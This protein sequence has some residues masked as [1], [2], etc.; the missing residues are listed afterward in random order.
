MDNKTEKINW[1]RNF[2]E[3]PLWNSDLTI[4]GEAVGTTEPMIPQDF[5][6]KNPNTSLG[7]MAEQTQKI[8][9]FGKV[10]N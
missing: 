9:L 3:A 10:I 5:I 6:E 8:F 4:Q 2:L 1:E 7:R